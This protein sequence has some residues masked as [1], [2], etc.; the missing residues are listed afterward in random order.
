[1]RHIIFEEAPN[2][3]IALLIKSSAFKQQ[4]LQTNYI[5]P[6]NK[7]GV[8]SKDV[9]AFTLK[10]SGKNISVK[11]IKE[12]LANLL[13]ALDSLG[14]K[15]LYVADAPY[16]KT[17]A[18]QTKA[19]PHMG[20]VLP[21]KIKGYEHMNVVLGVNHQALIYNPDL[22]AKLDSSLHALASGV[23]GRYQAPGS[24]IIHSAQYPESYQDIA[25]ALESLHQYSHLTCDIEA[26]SL[27]FN[28]AGIGTIAFA[29]DKHN[30]LAFACDYKT[31]EPHSGGAGQPLYGCFSK[32]KE[33]RA[34]LL[35][36]FLT[37]KGEIT[38][39]NATYDL[40]VIIY[41]L[42]MRNALD[43][44]TLLVG[45]ETMTRSFQ[46]TK[47]IAYLATNSTAG[48]VLGLKALAHEYA[49]NWAVE[50][51]DI[52]KVPLNKLLEY[53]LVDALC[54]W[55]VKQKYTHIMKSDKQ[56]DLYECLMKPS[57]KTIIQIE[58]TGMPLSATKVQE[59]KGKLEAIQ[60][61]HLATI[62]SSPIIAVLNLLVQTS[63]METANAK[64]K[65]KQHPLEKFND[66][67][68]NPNSGPQLQKLLY[69]QMGLPVI[70]F[71]DTKQPATGAD[72]I[73]KLINHTQ[74]PAYKKLLSALISYGEVAKILTT[75]IPAFE[76]AILKGDGVVWLHGNLNLGGTVSGRLSSSDP[77]LQNLPAGNTGSDEKQLYGKL[78]KACFEA[79]SGWLFAGADFNSLEDYVS[80]LTTRDPNK[81]KVYTDG[82][83]GHCLR[84]F[85]YFRDKCPD[86]V[87]TVASINSMKKKYPELR[88]DSK[89]PTFALTYQG[90]W[91]TLVNNLG[92]E[93]DKAKE[94]EAGYHELYKV[95]DEYIQERL[96]QASQDGFVDVAFGLRV[97][98][99]LLKQ[100]VFGASR[101]PFEA[102]AEG[103]TAGNAMGQS[104]GL[105]NSRA[106]NAFMQKVWASK[107][108]LDIKPCAL[109]HDAIYILI[110]DDIEV[111]EWA[112]KELILAMQ[113]QELPELQHPTVKLGAA[114]DIYWP[115]W[116]N[117]TT[118]P[119][120]ADLA[121]IREVCDK[122]KGIYLEKQKETV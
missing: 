111:V 43:T 108:R 38:W 103:R 17:L 85:S 4:E 78:I 32:N 81:L 110:R 122:A 82:Y 74:E 121:T 86:I 72:T 24:G 21:C 49:G 101:M 57:L 83:D 29:W 39:H 10:Y 7:Q 92:F 58:L 22:Q 11:E 46:D 50:V 48:N 27:R 87:D 96:K 51:K 99:P 115:S 69:E 62:Q 1:M 93:A 23:A 90:T 109:I 118:I 18:G 63:A 117:A 31:H 112:N 45:L 67:R 107:Y 44:T 60:E 42:W 120:N 105:L 26:F 41:T 30:G 37:Y 66:V 13:P 25:A 64:L 55:F 119:N 15:T 2:Y 76:K 68:F 84:A 88:Q 98:T 52:R 100:V 53:N 116:A 70:D 102:A 54:T 94:I 89:G 113:W 40:K 19:D 95:S 114:L 6:L 106:A 3:S 20:Y 34:L 16:F 65:V 14:V 71:T 104:Y 5:N 80:A 12:Y 9:I 47:I 79:P 8:A 61:T 91:H 75:F 77:N 36:F 97:R 35:Y 56:E 59:V 33:V 28:E 73:R